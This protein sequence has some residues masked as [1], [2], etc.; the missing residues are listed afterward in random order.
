TRAGPSSAGN[1]IAFSGSA[2]GRIIPSTI[3][4][5]SAGIW[6][7][8]AAISMSWALMSRIAARTARPIEF[9]LRLAAVIWSHG[10][11]AVSGVDT[12]TFSRGRPD[13][14][15]AIWA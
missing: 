7:R 12:R 9:V 10:V 2:L 1:G 4:I 5:S 3:S 15:A 14:W 11:W 6:K 8:A 13:S